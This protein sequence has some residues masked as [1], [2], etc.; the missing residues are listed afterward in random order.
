MSA[1]ATSNH[2]I[3]FSGRLDARTAPVTAKPIGTTP[4]RTLEKS[5][6][7]ADTVAGSAVWR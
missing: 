3:R 4:T 6:R 5:Q 1:A 7:Y 2:P